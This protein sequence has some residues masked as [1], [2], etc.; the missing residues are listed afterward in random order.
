MLRKEDPLLVVVDVA[1][2]ADLL[3]AAAEEEVLERIEKMT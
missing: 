1:S 2:V 3:I